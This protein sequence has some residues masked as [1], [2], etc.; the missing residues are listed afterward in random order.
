VVVNPLPEISTINDTTITIQDVITLTT[1]GGE[2][3]SWSPDI[4]LNCNDCP[5]PIASPEETILYQVTVTDSNGCVSSRVINIEVLIPDLFIPSG[6]S[7]NG[8]GVNDLVEVRSLSIISMN[9]KIYDRWGALIFESNDQ[10]R[11]WDGTF[12]GTN[13]DGGVYVYKFESKMVDGAKI[14]QSGTITLF[15]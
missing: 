5:D 9:I 13:L 3:Y 4:Y 1:T 8:D 6:F 2:V 14:E 12:N 15:R 11:S 7:P 10:E